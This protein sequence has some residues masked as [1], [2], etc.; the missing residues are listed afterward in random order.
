MKFN[1]LFSA[2]LLSGAS[3]AHPANK[4]DN[5]GQGGAPEDHWKQTT[6]RCP[7]Y[8]AG[9]NFTLALTPKYICG[10]ARLGPTLLPLTLP[11]F[12][13]VDDYD[14]FGGL[15]PGEFLAQWFNTTTNSYNYPPLNGFQLDTASAPI[16]GRVAFAVGQLLDRFG[17]EF[18][19][20]VSPE[21]APYNQRALPPSNLNMP[22]NGDSR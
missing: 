13:L 12:D 14:R 17:S 15:C 20:F 6:P 22:S 9:T 5:D 19:T 8:C 3:L 7:N 1:H 4:P 2:L 18:G 10:D 21:G 16:Q 11:V